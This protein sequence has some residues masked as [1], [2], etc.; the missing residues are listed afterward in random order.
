MLAQASQLGHGGVLHPGELVFEL[1]AAPEQEPVGDDEAENDAGHDPCHEAAAEFF[2]G[3]H[4]GFR[5]IL[6]KVFHFE[7]SLR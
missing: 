7:L 4:D 2:L 6:V 1:I 5:R 3:D